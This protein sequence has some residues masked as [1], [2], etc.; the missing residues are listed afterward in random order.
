MIRIGNQ[1]SCWTPRPTE[2]FDY[3]I[4][5]GFDAFEW[6]PDKKPGGGW[7]ESDLNPAERQNIRHTAKEKG[8]RLSVHARWQANLLHPEALELVRK[9]V[10]LARDLGAVL[11]NIHLYHEAGIERYVSVCVNWIQFPLS[12][13]ACA[14]ILGMRI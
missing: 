13:L 6:F 11:L 10:E 7:D 1:T 14:W 3:A 8:I 12:T 9:D 5:N 4:E 2:P